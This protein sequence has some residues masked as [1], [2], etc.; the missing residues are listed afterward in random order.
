MTDYSGP[1][2]ERYAG[3][4]QQRRERLWASPGCLN[5]EPVEESTLWNEQQPLDAGGEAR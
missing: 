4:H 5:L 2:D 3:K 1:I